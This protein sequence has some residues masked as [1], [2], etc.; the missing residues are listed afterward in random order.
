LTIGIYRLKV[1]LLIVYVSH[2]NG[3]DLELSFSKF[4]KKVFYENLKKFKACIDYSSR[5]LLHQLNITVLS[6]YAVR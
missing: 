3:L 5:Q 6:Y 4:S 2:L 1:D